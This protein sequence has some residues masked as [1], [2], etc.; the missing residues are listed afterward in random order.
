MGHLVNPGIVSLAAA[1]RTVNEFV[2]VEQFRK[3]LANRRCSPAAVLIAFFRLCAIPNRLTKQRMRVVLA[4]QSECCISAI[5]KHHTMDIGVV[6]YHLLNVVECLVCTFADYGSEGLFRSIHIR[7]PRQVAQAIG[8][9]ITIA[10][11][12]HML[13]NLI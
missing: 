12:A 13:E 11:R 3:Y 10:F 1:K 8:A 2:M 6:L 9:D 4:C 5:R 7:L